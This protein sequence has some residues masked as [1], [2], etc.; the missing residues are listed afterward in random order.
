MNLVN[1][2]AEQIIQNGF[3]IIEDYYTGDEIAVIFGEI[4]AILDQAILP[5]S[6]EEI[7]S[8][9]DQKYLFLKKH[10]GVIKSRCYD[11]FGLMASLNRF[12]NKQIITDISKEIYQTPVLMN[13]CQVRVDDNSMD[14]DLPLHQ[15]LNQLSVFNLTVWVPLKDVLDRESGGLQ[16]S[17]GSHKLGL[18]KHKEFNGYSGV[19]SSELTKVK[20]PVRVPVKKGSAIV[21]HPYLVHGTLPNKS[22][23]IRWTST[24]RFNELS[25]INYL[26]DEKA[27]LASGYDLYHTMPELRKTIFPKE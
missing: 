6:P 22:S 18:L 25:H 7:E 4:E 14:R 8:S 3:C 15:E 10:H 5:I 12:I 27:D 11:M 23:S 20:N 16:V 19:R 2:Y 24:A 21:F 9:I 17:P 26:K 1:N 13:N